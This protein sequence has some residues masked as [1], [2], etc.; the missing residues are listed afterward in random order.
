MSLVMDGTFHAVGS[1]THEGSGKN[2]EYMSELPYRR[3]DRGPAQILISD[4]TMN[5][6]IN[7][8]TELGWYDFS[9]IMNGNTINQYI[10]GF[11][12]AFGTSTE[13]RVACK[14]VRGSTK[15]TLDGA[16]GISK[17]SGLVDLHV[18]NPFADNDR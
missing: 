4:Y 17:L 1:E 2:H 3:D 9:Q 18:E 5:T 6:L 10:G 16:R 12:Q 8:S 11:E 15:M 13:V 7:A 14:P